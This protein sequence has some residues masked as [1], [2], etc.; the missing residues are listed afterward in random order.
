MVRP[1]TAITLV[2]AFALPLLERELARLAQS[3]GAPKQEPK[4]K[5]KPAAKKPT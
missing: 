3:K 4:P 2:L 5:P 1:R